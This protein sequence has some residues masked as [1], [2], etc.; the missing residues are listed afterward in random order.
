L[1]AVNSLSRF[2]Y[3]EL[4]NNRALQAITD[5]SGQVEGVAAQIDEM[6][7]NSAALYLSALK[8]IWG[9]AKAL[10]GDPHPIRWLWGDG[11]NSFNSAL[12]REWYRSEGIVFTEFPRQ[13]SFDPGL[14]RPKALPIFKAEGILNR[15]I[16]SLRDL[17]YKI[18][19]RRDGTRGILYPE[20]LYQTVVEYNT[21]V[22]QAFR[23]VGVRFPLT[24]FLI[25]KDPKLQV[26]LL[27]RERSANACTT[28]APG[29]G[30]EIGSAVRV[31]N[32]RDPHRKRRTEWI[33][34][35]FY[36]VDRRQGL[37]HVQDADADID[38]WVPRSDLDR[39]GGEQ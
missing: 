9:Q 24:P 3:V 12:A 13:R 30:L 4:A 25:E 26:E 16:R 29:Y 38:L 6:G 39:V 1:V 2:V 36:V 5:S 35:R 23:R 28:S 22:T 7:M 33:P 34:G 32:P 37:F 8:S 21:R 10:T 18:D 14:T 20:L 11:Q 27:R 15:A 31:R 17:A 19:T